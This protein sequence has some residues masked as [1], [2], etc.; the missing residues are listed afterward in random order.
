M[1]VLQDVTNAPLNT[2]ELT[3]EMQQISDLKSKIKEALGAISKLPSH[4]ALKRV[5]NLKVQ[6]LATSGD[7]SMAHTGRKP[8]SWLL[9]YPALACML[10]G[11]YYMEC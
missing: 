2:R 7:P 1:P 6:Y 5:R 4:E 11:G 9:N 3:A 10:N 8:K